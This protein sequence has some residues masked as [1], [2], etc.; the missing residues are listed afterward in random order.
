MVD[1]SPC[2]Y[3]AAAIAVGFAGIGPVLVKEMLLGRG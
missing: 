2:F 3:V 1:L